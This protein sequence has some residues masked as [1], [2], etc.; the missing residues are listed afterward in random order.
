MVDDVF[1]NPI[2]SRYLMLPENN[3]QIN[4]ASN[5]PDNILN[6]SSPITPAILF[7]TVDRCKIYKQDKLILVL[8]KAFKQGINIDILKEPYKLTLLYISIVENLQDVATFLL[9]QGANPNIQNC[10]SDTPLH[11]IAKTE[12]YTQYRIEI[13][14]LLIKFTNLE[15]KDSYNFTIIQVAVNWN[16]K[17][18]TKLLI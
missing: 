2:N 7:K 11:Y 14:E 18:L 17:E 4:Q 3:T 5:Y 6:S 10:F 13:V 12:M 9:E 15:L 8:K 16:N 1:I